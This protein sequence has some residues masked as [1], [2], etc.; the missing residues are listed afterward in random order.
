MKRN[1]EACY[2]V[3]IEEP[4]SV[5][6]FLFPQNKL[7][8]MMHD[9]KAAFMECTTY[10]RKLQILTLSPLTIEESARFFETTI[11]MVRKS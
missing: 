6:N 9:L 10:K 1:L 4:E 7:E 3:Q 8:K 11:H 5:S 2:E